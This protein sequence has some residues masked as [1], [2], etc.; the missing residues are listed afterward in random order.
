[1]T[2]DVLEEDPFRLDFADDPGNVGPQMALVIGSPA[3]PCLAERLAGVSCEDGV[4]CAA[5]RSSVECG[6][7]IPYRSGR[8]IS[9]PLRGD[10][11]AARVFLPLDEGAGVEAGFG[12]HEAHIEAAAACAEGE[13]VSG[14]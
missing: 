4:E 11:D 2:G 14:T 13:A 7:V 9:G 1:M 6:E 5:E 8:E 10:E 12:E 3:L